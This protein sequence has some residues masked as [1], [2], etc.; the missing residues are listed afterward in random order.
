MQSRTSK[1]LLAIVFITLVVCPLVFI[2]RGDAD[3]ASV[4]S[5]TP[6][7]SNESP[8]ILGDTLTVSI[9]VSGVTKLWGWSLGLSWD[10]SILQMIDS[11]AEGSFLS[12]AGQT[13]FMSSPV[14]NQ[15]GIVE[16]INNALMSK[17]S[18]SGSGDLFYA[19]FKII[20]YGSTEIKLL[21]VQ[22]YQPA[23][24]DGSKPVISATVHSYTF[25]SDEPSTCTVDPLV[26][27]SGV[28]FLVQSG[29]GDVSS[30]VLGPSPS[31]VNSSVVVDLCISGA[32]N[33]YSWHVSVDWDP[34]VL[35]LVKVQQGSFLSDWGSTAMVGSQVSL[36][37]FVAGSIGGGLGAAFMESAVSGYSSGVLATLTFNVT[38]FGVS[39][40]IVSGGTL[41][42]SSGGENVAVTT[43]GATITAN[44]PPVSKPIASFQ[45]MPENKTTYTIGDVIS[46]NASLSCPG[47]DTVNGS[48]SCPITDYS[49][50]VELLNGTTLTT[51]T[52][53]T[54]TFTATV[55]GS[56][57]VN[58]TVSAV[59]PHPPSSVDLTC[60]PTLVV[61]G[62]VLIVILI[63]LKT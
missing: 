11:V 37:D 23:K 26:V 39:A 7:V 9:H 2:V 36:W 56:L 47:Y 46:V 45:F 12:T 27:P 43:N 41:R 40:P 25:S 24:D 63:V 44:Q 48:E 15:E 57:R 32:V 16:N 55:E 14:N 52:G 58:L 17:N 34:A 5:V 33:V 10:P 49:W 1:I 20:G 42:S 13:L 18:S 29:T 38:G 50:L 62:L 4:V 51:F 53:Q 21:H 19:S 22:L 28:I 6:S 35:R 61:W 30:I 3:G 60:T 8:L 31:P 59:D 54:G